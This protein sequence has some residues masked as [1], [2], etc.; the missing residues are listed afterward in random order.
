MVI[1]GSGL[2]GMAIIEDT[3]PLKPKRMQVTYQGQT[4]WAYAGQWQKVTGKTVAAES[5][6]AHDLSQIT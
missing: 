5:R 1:P 6:A 2:D 4:Y 3:D